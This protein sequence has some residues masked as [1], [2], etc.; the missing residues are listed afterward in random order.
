MNSIRIDRFIHSKSI[1]TLLPILREWVEVNRL[2]THSWGWK[3][4][5]WWCNERASVNTWAAA[6]W[7]AGGKALEEFYDEKIYRRANYQGRCDLYFEFH[8]HGF[9]AETKHVWL[10]AGRRSHS[11][12]SV[13]KK[14]QVEACKDVQH[15][16]ERRGTRLGIV[17]AVP[18]FPK[19]DSAHATGLL[20]K[21]QLQVLEAQ[22]DGLAWV[23]P[24]QTR[25]LLWT[26]SC[27]YPGVAAILY[28][29]Q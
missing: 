1:G 17:F 27:I 4:C 9:I 3:D 15:I 19:S 11:K 29:A 7:R 2:L 22:W 16:K 6:V 23:F 10:S 26:D 8:G 25:Q 12:D 13:L 18:Y 14:A 5:P 20:K 28:K 24:P 21:W